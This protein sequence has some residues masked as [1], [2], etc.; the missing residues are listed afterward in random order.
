MIEIV[1]HATLF[2][3][4]MECDWL[5]CSQPPLLSSMVVEIYNRTQDETIVTKSLPALLKEHHFWNSGSFPFLGFRYEINRIFYVV[6][7][8]Q[9][10]I[11]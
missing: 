8:G 2:S 10:K 5:L 11:T 4:L 9:T 7:N 6:Q 3:V 1:S